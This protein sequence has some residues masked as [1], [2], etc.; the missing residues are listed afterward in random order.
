[1]AAAVSLKETKHSFRHYQGGGEKGP[2][3]PMIL[4]LAHVKRRVTPACRGLD[5]D[6]IRHIRD[7]SPDLGIEMSLVDEQTRQ[8]TIF[9]MISDVCC[10]SSEPGLHVGV[11][12][13][14]GD[15]AA[16]GALPI[17]GGEV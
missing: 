11:V 4:R 14:A 8:I 17:R 6:E 2:T 3:Y 15:V 12:W 10:L 5:F 13:V 1:M 7:A 9:I 16:D